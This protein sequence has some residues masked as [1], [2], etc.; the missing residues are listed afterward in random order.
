MSGQWL[1]NFVE[2]AQVGPNVTHLQQH[3]TDLQHEV[4]AIAC[5]RSTQEGIRLT[6][7]LP[8]IG[9]RGIEARQELSCL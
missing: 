4:S 1:L 7:I 5:G 6:R 2:I 3:W 9:R 8:R